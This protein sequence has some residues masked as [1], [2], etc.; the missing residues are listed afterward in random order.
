MCRVS[1]P[2]RRDRERWG[3]ETDPGGA[4]MGP[5]EREMDP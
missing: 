3:V 2:E 5:K 4:E 1:G